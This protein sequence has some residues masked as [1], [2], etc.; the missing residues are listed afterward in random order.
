[1]PVDTSIY[2]QL[3][4]PANPL[5][6]A[7]QVVGLQN[8][9]NQNK[10]FQLQT[11]AR[12]A[13]GNALTQATDP[14]TGQTDYDKAFAIASQDP[15]AQYALGEFSADRLTQQGQGIQNQRG[16]QQLGASMAEAARGAIGALPANPSPE[17][18]V[19][20][21]NYLKSIGAVSP[22]AADATLGSMPKNPGQLKDWVDNNFRVPGL[23]PEGAMAARYG[24]PTSIDTGANIE[25]RDVNRFTG[26]VG[27]PMA[28]VRKTAT[29]FEMMQ[30][31]PTVTTDASGR[32]QPG[33]VANAD[34]YD[35]YGQPKAN[36]YAQGGFLPSGAPAGVGE[37]FQVT[38][39]G[40]AEAYQNLRDYVSGSG[41]RLY[42]LRQALGGLQNART[43]P[44]TAQVNTIKSFLQAQ[45]PDWLS[46]YLPGV[47]PSKIASY[48]E[49]NKY[50]TQY[51]SGVAGSFGPRTDQQ[52][53]TTLSGNASTHISNLA[54]QDVVRAN[55]A[56]ERM[57]AAQALAFERSG[58]SPDRFSSWATGWASKV[59]PR[60][61]VVD[62]LPADKRKA[63]LDGMGAPERKRF[64]DSFR[65]GANAGIPG[66]ADIVQ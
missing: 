38:G 35:Q 16:S 43:G 55:I 7:G 57:K 30:R 13:W 36:S 6:M 59:D 19:S 50:L 66:L 56:L 14:K 37:G 61:F 33:S 49:A 58:Q 60:A 47:D 8:S 29:P 5:Q 26:T 22:Q 21:V 15:A 48:D 32:P 45:S 12:Q 10:L 1:M 25:V 27:E 28:T 23:G 24:Q 64:M 17:Q 52:L 3:Q 34:L 42:Q 53:A 40:S 44:G 2:G 4:P 63:M 31:T 51:A 41:D 18:V 20:T 65:A 9:L 46:H 62:M 39:K 54:A 11:Q